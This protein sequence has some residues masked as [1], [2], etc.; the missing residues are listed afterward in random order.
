MAATCPW[1]SAPRVDAPACPRCGANYA[2]AELIKAHGRA[3]MA[4]ATAA[5]Q[6]PVMAQP[7]PA[8]IVG[9]DEQ[10]VDDPVLEW[11]LCIGA[12]PAALA[13]GTLFHMLTPSLQRI[14]FGMPVHELGHALTAWLCGYFA[15]PTLWKT[16]VPESRG[17]LAPLLLAGAIAYGIYRAWVAGKPAY[18]ALLAALLVVQAIGTFGIREERAEMLITFAGDGMG[19]VLAAVL[20]ASFFFGKRTELYKGWLRWGFVLIGAAAFVDMFATWWVAQ[21]NTDVIPFGENEGSGLSDPMKLLEDYGWQTSTIVRRY[22]LVGAASLAGLAAVYA[23][24]VL[25]ARRKA[26]SV[27]RT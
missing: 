14:F 4:P 25:R 10:A 15:I 27:R 17:F 1:C 22:V 5:E 6:A 7:V 9:A 2:K 8:V 11:K 24:G 20:M 26:D 23:W 21:Y 12:I 16:I 13:L 3:A 18:I 19:M